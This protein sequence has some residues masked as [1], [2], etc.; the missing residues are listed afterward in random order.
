MCKQFICYLICNLKVF[1]HRVNCAG[2][3]HAIHICEGLFPE[4][5]VIDVQEVK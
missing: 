5:R 2:M 1:E 3:I 4:A